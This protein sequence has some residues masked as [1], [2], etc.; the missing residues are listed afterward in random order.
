MA[1]NNNI[2]N[3]IR[4]E[5]FPTA[6][7]PGCGCGTVLN[8]F[9]HMLDKVGIDKRDLILVTGIGCSSWIPSPYLEADTLHT[10]HGRPI[11]FATGVKVMKPDK[12]VVVIAGDGD[13]AGIGGNHLMHAARRNV[14]LKV[15]LVNNYIYG[16]TGGQ[17]APTTP[18]GVPTTTTPYG[19]PEPPMNIAEIV[20]AAGADYVARWTT[21]HVRKLM[22]SMEQAMKKKGFSLIEIMSQCPVSYGKRVKLKKGSDMLRY[23]RDNSVPIQKTGDLTEE[24]LSGKIVIGKLVDRERTEFTATLNAIVE[25]REKEVGT[26]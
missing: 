10:T 6:F 25:K 12:Y 3:Y 18:T 21:Y 19:N 16:M 4:E 2:L 1:A 13:L 26:S 8:C 5:I 23:F 24:E 15:F 20:T 11:A 14:G 7:C 17:V 22:H 9:V